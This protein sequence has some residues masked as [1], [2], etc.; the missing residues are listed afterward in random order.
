LKPIYFFAAFATLAVFSIVALL[1]VPKLLVSP[2]VEKWDSP[3]IKAIISQTINR[4]VNMDTAAL[5]LGWS[6]V[7][8]SMPSLQITER[9]G[10]PFLNCGQT[11]IELSMFPL[12]YDKVVIQKV[13][14]KGPEIFLRRCSDCKWNFSDIPALKDLNSITEVKVVNARM[15]LQDDRNIHPIAMRKTDW[16]NLNFSLS[17]HFGPIYWPFDLTF[18]ECGPEPVGTVTV[19]GKGNGRLDQW[20][21]DKYAIKAE[22]RAL[23]PLKLSIFFGPVP[24][25]FGR[26]DLNFMGNAVGVKELE[27]LAQL[28]ASDLRISP[29]GLSP[30]RVRNL[31]T[32]AKVNMNPEELAWKNLNV[33]VGATEFTS[34]GALKKW[35]SGVP[36]YDAHVRGNVDDLGE[37][38]KRID[39]PWIV[40]GLKSLPRSMAFKGDVDVRGSISSK[41]GAEK[42]SALATFRNADFL[43]KKDGV[44]AKDLNGKVAFDQ[45]GMQV[46]AVSG[47]FDGSH[48]DA[49]GKLV[50]DRLVELNLSVPS[51]RIASVRKFLT[52]IGSDSFEQFVHSYKFKGK[53][54]GELKDLGAKVFGEPNALQLKF[55]T[56]LDRLAFEDGHGARLLTVTS[57]IARYDTKTFVLEKVKGTL[58][59]GTFEAGGYANQTPESPAN[60][61]AEAQD[62]D[63][64]CLKRAIDAANLKIP[65]LDENILSG[66]TGHSKVTLTGSFKNPQI[67]MEC[68]M[69]DLTYHPLGPE[70]VAHLKS[71]QVAFQGNQFRAADL[72]MS[73]P[74]SQLNLTAT[75]DNIDK[76]PTISQLSFKNSTLDIGEFIAF[77][78][79]KS[80]PASIQDF[81]QTT[82]KN[83]PF[84]NLKGKVGITCACTFTGK[85]ASIQ[86]DGSIQTLD[87]SAGSHHVNLTAG[88]FASRPDNLSLNFQKVVG[89]LNSSPF[90]A[91]GTILNIDPKLQNC[92][93]R[94]ETRA[95]VAIADLTKILND[96]A[97]LLLQLQSKRALKFHAKAVVDTSGAT[98]DFN[99]DVPS[100]A[101]VKIGSKLTRISQPAQTPVSLS[102]SVVVNPAGLSINGGKIDLSGPVLGFTSKAKGII[103]GAETDKHFAVNID[104]PEKTDIPKLLALVPDM[105]ISDKLGDLTGQAS[106]NIHFG[107]KTEA[108]KLAVNLK[109]VNVA[110]PR[111]RLGNLQGTLTLPPTSLLSNQSI[112]PLQI[113]LHADSTH[114]EG[115]ELTNLNGFLIADSTPDDVFE[116]KMQNLTSSIA[117]GTLNV[118]G[119]YLA[120]DSGDLD[121]DLEIKNVDADTIYKQM[122]GL[123]E[124]VSGSLSLSLHAKAST[125]D[126]DK[127]RTTLSASGE[128]HGSKGR[129]A[130]FSALQAKL[131]EARILEQGVLGFSAG[132]LL[133]PLEKWENG[134]FDSLD[135]TFQIDHGVL[136]LKEFHFRNPDLFLEVEGTADLVSKEVHMKGSGTMARFEKEG[137]LGK[138]GSVFSIGGVIDF[139]AKETSIHTPDIPLIGGVSG[140]SRHSFI[141]QVNA[142]LN[143][144]TTI[145]KGIT[146][147]FHWTSEHGHH[148]V[149]Q[150]NERQE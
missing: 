112:P 73:T 79:A 108:P 105:K 51:I 17:H 69:K 57:G 46:Q 97:N 120:N 119:A 92:Q 48:F 123:K 27:G 60:F 149:S 32:S 15:H 131:E 52:L 70:H 59:S 86:G 7:K 93:L 67:G 136:D 106:G 113:N 99:L 116:L 45:N 146:K 115:V 47:T 37:L 18:S 4:P 82:V 102:G 96:Q 118:N 9:D 28:K 62:I 71:G 127:I 25:I 21:S 142:N 42:F 88:T 31:A 121:L 128:F 147:S 12:L 11:D 94:I 87:F 80:N 134:E 55:N 77:G 109:I 126:V 114:I 85:Q 29:P 43:L 138:V 56:K 65:W 76:R 132:N 23:E 13:S 36:Q 16:Q 75:I 44:Q 26:V 143:Q 63:I 58:G 145:A 33:N 74:N 148:R 83:L 2:Q 122:M 140:A 54:S 84:Q 111:F 5:S 40:T 68:E 91:R 34:D 22:A 95:Q 1:M 19:K 144:P 10:A 129:I 100:D 150:S 135:G 124:E 35:L 125:A 24:E 141:F 30:L 64:A 14:V 72:V 104:I 103:H 66:Q 98:A 50:P 117:K 20:E 137:K 38:L 133:A 6:V 49:V 8:I 130:Q 61:S 89:T 90:I 41:V 110:V 53:M 3:K 39:A 81:V 101:C 107:G 139:V 78:S